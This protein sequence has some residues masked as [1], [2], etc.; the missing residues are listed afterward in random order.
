[1]TKLLPLQEDLFKKWY[2]SLP[3]VQSGQLNPNPD[4]PEHFY[5]YRGAWLAQNANQD[6]LGHFP[7]QFKQPGHPRDYLGGVDTRQMNP[8]DLQLQDLLGRPNINNPMAR[9]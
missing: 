2:A 3:N 6:S 4:D 5:D 7:S 8:E 9:Y 1:M